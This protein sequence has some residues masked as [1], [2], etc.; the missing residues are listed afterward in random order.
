MARLKIDNCLSRNPATFV[1]R[2]WTK[3][4]VHCLTNNQA[5]RTSFFSLPH[6]TCSLVFVDP[7]PSPPPLAHSAFSLCPGGKLT[8]HTDG[9]SVNCS[10]FVSNSN[11]LESTRRTVCF[12]H[13]KIR[14]CPVKYLK[15]KKRKKELNIRKG[16]KKEERTKTL[17][18]ER[19][20]CQDEERE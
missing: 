11:Q 12:V 4:Q 8:R 16:R 1:R 2:R 17:E 7:S 19:L 9:E 20:L 10:R 5:N 15:K 13:F 3:K 14:I 6:F 18:K